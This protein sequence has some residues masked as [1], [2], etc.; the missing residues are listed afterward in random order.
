M[1]RRLLI[2][3]AVLL[4]AAAI[5]WTVLAWRPAI[6]PITPPP[7]NAFNAALVQRGEQLAAVGNCAG[8]HTAPNGPPHAGGVP[9]ATPFGTLYGSNLTPDLVSGIGSW[10]QAAFNRA[11]REG[12]T[13]EGRH[14]YPA[15]PYDHFT[16]V[17][18]A[19]LQ[20]LYA[21]LMTREPVRLSATP[22]DLRFPF[23]FRP[24]VAGWNLLYLDKQPFKPDPAQGEPFNRGAY[25]VESLGH[26][27]GCHSPRNGFGAE[28]RQHALTGGE[29]EGWY[30][31]AINARSPSPQPWTVDQLTEYLRTGIASDRA[32]AGGPMQGVVAGLAHAN[33]ADVRAI[34]VYVTTL[35]GAP[36]PQRQTVASATRQ[37]AAQA[38]AG[39]VPAGAD[40]QTALGATVY[41]SACASCHDAGRKL[42][43]NGALRMPLAIAVHDPDP[44]SFLRIV[45]D[46]IRP[47][48]GK[49]GRWMP[50][51]GG[52][53]TDEQ[54]A[55]LAAYLRRTAADAP[56]W[57]ELGRAVEQSRGKPS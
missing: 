5:G 41:A 31:P 49:H 19:D 9:L 11:M 2:V 54:L 16:R 48:D 57:P 40:A 27:G 17:T 6:A 23:N 34:A 56:P 33:E 4:L 36:S 26:C 14:L 28:Q 39:T 38:L 52:T 1:V 24:I 12:I 43:S 51:F 46:G 7:R 32:I 53:L 21:Y 22:N 13:R 35:M 18:D 20:A 55:A 44:R 50:A 37:R 47:P 3:L 45:R 8:C 30:V 25:L 29:A 10:S 42:S 15:F